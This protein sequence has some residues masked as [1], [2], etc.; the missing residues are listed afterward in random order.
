VW[1]LVALVF[2]GV[3]AVGFFMKWMRSIFQN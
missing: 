3:L 1:K 2:G